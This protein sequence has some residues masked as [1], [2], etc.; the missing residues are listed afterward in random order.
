MNARK[1]MAR[2]GGER[3]VT[4]LEIMVALG[5]LTLIATL[6]YGALDGMARSREGLTRIGDRY[7]QGRNT[8]GRI[9]RELQSSFI[10]AHTPVNPALAT[11]TT[12]F[13]GTDQS[14]MDRLD[15]T[16][17]AHR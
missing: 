5:I 7:S 12:I 15:F 14:Q 1:A 16:T 4:L 2:R 11:R 6:I 8:L 9:T 13:K 10:S 17:F 3:G